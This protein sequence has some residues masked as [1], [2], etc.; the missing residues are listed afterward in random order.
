MAK[1][2][3]QS[4]QQPRQLKQQV[5]NSTGSNWIKIGGHPHPLLCTFPKSLLILIL[6]HKTLEIYLEN[7]TVNINVELF[8][9][10]ILYLKELKDFNIFDKAVE[11]G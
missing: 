10:L 8:N 3:Q 9:R 2:K 1:K 5:N 7:K 4:K 11:W 6:Q